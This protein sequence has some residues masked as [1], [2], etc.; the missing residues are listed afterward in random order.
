MLFPERPRYSFD[1]KTHI[2]LQNHKKH[3]ISQTI[4]KIDKNLKKSQNALEI[5]KILK[6]TKNLNLFLFR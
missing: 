4:S 1:R 6:T 3:Q 2:M 5:P